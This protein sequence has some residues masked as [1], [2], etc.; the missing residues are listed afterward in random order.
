MTA[1]AESRFDIEFS[2]ELVQGADS[3]EVRERL[4]DLFKLPPNSLERLFSGRPLVLKRDLD[5]ATAARYADAFRGAGAILRLTPSATAA[6]RG[7]PEQTAP[8]EEVPQPPGG[9]TAADGGLTLAPLGTDMEVAAVPFIPRDID[10]TYL[11]LVP[12]HN[13]TLEDCAPPPRYV[14]I[15]DISHLTLIPV[16][17]VAPGPAHG[18]GL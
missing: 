12:G 4:R 3:R 9:P 1:M 17:P 10:T 18:L 2:G 7:A 14:R 15:P 11:S 8:Q 5:P 13:W 6:G 16:E